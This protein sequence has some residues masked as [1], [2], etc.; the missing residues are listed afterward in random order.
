MNKILL[1]IQREYLARVRKKSFIVMTLLGPLFFAFVM[2]VPVWYTMNDSASRTIL[3]HDPEGFIKSPLLP[4][5][6]YSFD[7][8][9][10]SHI[11][12]KKIFEA[13]DYA[14][15]ISLS[16]ANAASLDSI[17]FYVKEYIPKKDILFLEKTIETELVKQRLSVLGIDSSKISAILSPI[18]FRVHSNESEQTKALSAGAQGFLAALLIY[19][20]IFLYSVQVM[21]GV[22]EEKANRIVEVIISSVK[23]FQLMMGK[24]I[25]I[26]LL[27]LTQFALWLT[28]T[29]SISAAFTSRYDKVFEMY[30][31]QNIEQQLLITPDVKQA[32]EMNEL[33]NIFSGINF[34]ELIVCFLF[35]F[36]GGYLLYSA[37]F[38]VIGAIADQESDM[39]QFI[40][41][42]TMPLLISIVMLTAILQEPH[43]NM[44][45]WLSIIPLT[46]PVAMMVRVPFGVPVAELIVSVLLLVLTFIAVT[47]LSARIYR[48]GILMYGKKPTLKEVIRWTLYKDS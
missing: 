6:G 38:A 15:V 43:G 31:N 24:I 23:P 34:T 18:A 12:V 41:P 16:A 25:G 10:L 1:V 21:K 27:S 14:A 28:L 20:F 35:Y 8:L 22:I 11:D 7:K 39:Q 3:V 9:S 45:F 46:S 19:F 47:W 26:A 36:F 40:L 17:D 4:A 48:V 42:V 32:L 33:I 30:N 29:I 2:I 5:P 13:T 44:A 37:M